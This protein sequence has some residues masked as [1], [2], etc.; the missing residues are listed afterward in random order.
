MNIWRNALALAATG[1]LVASLAFAQGGGQTTSPSSTDQG[2]AKPGDQGSP[3]TTPDTQ[4]AE[5]SQADKPD[6][7]Q[8]DAGNDAGKGQ[9]A[10]R[11]GRQEQIR[12]V[13][14]A[15]KEKGQDPGPIDGKLGPKTQAALKAF[16]QAEGLTPTGRPDPETMAKL[17][18][19]EGGAS[20]PSA[21]PSASPSTAPSSAPGGEAPTGEKKDAPETEQKQGQQQ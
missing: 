14:Q 15:L 12:A 7:A 21:S 10:A 4:D 11:G 5:Q 8:S 17:G 13:Q 16:Q 6:A 19:S 18:V 2:G 3:S 1:V 20:T 9:R